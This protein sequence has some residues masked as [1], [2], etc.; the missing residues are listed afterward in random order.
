MLTYFQ[1]YKA[2]FSKQYFIKSQTRL[3]QILSILFFKISRI[4]FHL[5]W[6]DHKD[7]DKISR[8]LKYISRSCLAPSTVSE[9]NKGLWLLAEYLRNQY[10]PIFPFLLGL[11]QSW[12]QPANQGLCTV[13]VY[14]STLTLLIFRIQ[15]SIIWS[16]YS[17]TE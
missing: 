16:K 3:E 17:F 1:L 7:T 5:I 13:N 2:K 10:L 11:N 4:D 6:Q 8:L 15:S 12:K 9:K 14:P